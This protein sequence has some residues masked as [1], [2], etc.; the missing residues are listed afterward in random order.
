MQSL[1][2]DVDYL[3]KAQVDHLL[4]VASSNLR[5]AL[6]IR[7][8]WRTGIAVTELLNM[9]CTDIEFANGVIY[10]SKSASR[11]GSVEGETS[12]EP[13]RTYSDIGL[14]NG[15][16]ARKTKKRKSRRVPVD[17]ETLELIK[18]YVREKNVSRMDPIFD[19]CRQYVHVLIKKYGNEIGV[20][21][22]PQTLRHSFAIYLVR[23]G[24]NIRLIQEILGLSS[25]SSSMQSYLEFDR[26]DIKQVYDMVRF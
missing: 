23:S 2:K 9:T 20:D 11:R 3:D 12:H 10:V 15:S 17:S 26:A 8:F 1:E 24:I 22:H 16:N 14:S 19:I 4:D 6:I 21:I 25:F 5:D 13:E 18:K 7:I